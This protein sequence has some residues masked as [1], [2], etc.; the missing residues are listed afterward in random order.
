MRRTLPLTLGVLLVAGCS[1]AS[2]PATPRAKA[3]PAT[4][5]QPKASPQVPRPSGTGVQPGASPAATVEAPVVA[6]LPL[7]PPALKTPTDFAGHMGIRGFLAPGDE[8]RFGLATGGLTGAPGGSLRGLDGVGLIGVDGG[9]LIG[10]DGGT[11]IGPDGGTLIGPDGGTL[12]GSSRGALVGGTFA[13]QVGGALSAAEAAPLGGPVRGPISAPGR[14]PYLLLEEGLSSPVSQ[15]PCADAP[16]QEAG[17]EGVP[18]A[19][20]LSPL[21]VQAEALRMMLKAYTFA[22]PD[23]RLLVFKDVKLFDQA[24]SGKIRVKRAGDTGEV[25]IWLQ[26]HTG[27][28]GHAG[29]VTFHSPRRG[30]FAAQVR[31]PYM[32][33]LAVRGQ[34]DLTDGEALLDIATFPMRGGV[35][36][37]RVGRSKHQLF[38]RQRIEVRRGASASLDAPFTYSSATARELRTADLGCQRLRSTSV[39]KFLPDNTAV[40][41]TRLRVGDATEP[42]EA[43]W[44]LDGA[45]ATLPEGEASGALRAL[46]IRADE[47]P[48]AVESASNL[49][50]GELSLFTMPPPPEGP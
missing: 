49:S 17:A 33:L 9:T 25:H 43:R 16:G 6:V 3:Q 19:R 36:P 18:L 5:E 23:G 37:A 11:L 39:A 44:H 13:R 41:H 15:L 21:G 30:T 46:E 26:E 22:T 40:V 8:E 4:R 45:G 14:A 42:L 34:F 50:P 31:L 27:R 48:E 32:G 20:E 35:E 24:L 2:L 10:P 28:L 7:L 1:A 47:F 38:L 29:T 12:M